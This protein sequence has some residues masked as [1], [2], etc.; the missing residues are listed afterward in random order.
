MLRITDRYLQS[1]GDDSDEGC[2][3]QVV[4]SLL[5]ALAIVRLPWTVTTAGDT[6]VYVIPPVDGAVV[7]VAVLVSF[8]DIT[9]PTE[10]SV[11]LDPKENETPVEDLTVAI[12]VENTGL[13]FENVRVYGVLGGFARKD[14]PIKISLGELLTTDITLFGYL[15]IDPTVEELKVGISDPPPIVIS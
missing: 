6:E 12:P 11:I 8:S 2:P 10:V 3:P 15:E 5:G 14:V 9:E 1:L 4:R 7:R 13:V